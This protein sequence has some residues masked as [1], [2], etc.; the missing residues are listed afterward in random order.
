MN[1]DKM[2]CFLKEIK[3]DK[4]VIF[5][6]E[7][8]S[9]FERELFLSIQLILFERYNYHLDGLTNTH[10]NTFFDHLKKRDI[11]LDTKIKEIIHYAL[12]VYLILTDRNVSLG[13]NVLPTDNTIEDDDWEKIIVNIERYI[14]KY[15]SIKI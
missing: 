15:K 12:S 4:S 13:Y 1:I 7:K 9:S 11:V 5:E 10:F 6:F 2:E 8:I 14:E 3:K